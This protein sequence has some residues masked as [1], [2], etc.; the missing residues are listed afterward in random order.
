M[1]HTR[2]RRSRRSA[3]R[4]V[5]TGLA[6][7]AVAAC[8]TSAISSA[9]ETGSTS[10]PAAPA[11]SPS[12][13]AAESGST[14]S[15][16]TAPGSTS[17]AAGAGAARTA[18]EGMS[19]KSA[20]GSAAVR[21]CPAS[22]LSG[23]VGRVG[24]AAG[25]RYAPLVLTNT[26]STTC[27]LY[28]FPG[29]IMIDGNQDALRTRPRREHVTPHQVTLRPGASA[30]ARLHWTV[31][32]SGDERDCPSAAQLL[33]IPPDAKAYLMARFHARVCGDGRIDVRPMAPG[34]T[35]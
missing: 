4:L 23:R 10:P 16:A 20:E 11:G 6:L 5:A 29:L 25:N 13:P 34:S 30:H 26:S 1:E 32:P 9:A 7:S 28:G 8:G 19:A 27:R 17:R 12:P 18:A 35:I 2:N 31:V 21:R 22:A 3:P 24:A 15:F 14:N 33:V